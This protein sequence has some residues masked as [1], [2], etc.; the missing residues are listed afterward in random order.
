MKSQLCSRGLIPAPFVVSVAELLSSR[1]IVVVLF[2]A[3]L[4]PEAG[5]VIR[6]IP[7]I[8]NRI[9]WPAASVKGM[10]PE[11]WVVKLRCRKERL[12]AAVEA[13][14][15]RSVDVRLTD[16][17]RKAHLSDN[18]HGRCDRS[19]QGHQRSERFHVG[20]AAE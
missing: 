10:T 13:G 8:A 18:R 15:N 11:P 1:A 3:P 7:L 14:L 12:V 17:N 19:Q 5:N 4:R 16:L 9:N 2:P 6:S 20:R